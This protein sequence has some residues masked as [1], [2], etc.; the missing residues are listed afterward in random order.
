MPGEGLMKPVTLDHKLC[1]VHAVHPLNPKPT[2]GALIKILAVQN[3]QEFAFAPRHH[4]L[5]AHAAARF[6]DFVTIRRSASRPKR[7]MQKTQLVVVKLRRWW[8]AWEQ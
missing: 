5:A 1:G 7:V 4:A 3:K 6:G 2:P 8:G